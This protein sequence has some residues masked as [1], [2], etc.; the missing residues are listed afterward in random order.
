MRV[1][2]MYTRLIITEK[3]SVA[4]D[5]AKAL[6]ISN[7]KDGYMENGNTVITWAIG[8]LVELF[9]P[10]DYDKSLKNWSM[11][12]L[13]IIPEK[14][15]YKPIKRTLKQYRVV[16]KLIAGGIGEIVI[17]T[18]AGREGEV[19][20][21]TIIP[22]D[23]K[24]NMFRF[25]SSQSM[26]PN[27]VNQG[28]QN[29]KPSS[30]YD[31]LWEAG[32]SRQ[33]ADWMVGINGTRAATV[34]MN[35]MFSIGR[36]QTAVLA[37]LVDRRRDREIFIPEPYWNLRAHFSNEKGKWTGTWFNE[38]QTQFSTE[39][40]A[41]MVIECIEGSSGKVI[42]SEKQKGSKPPPF[43]YSLT[44]LQRDVN[45]KHGFSAKRT[46]E[47]AQACYEKHKCLSYPR[48]DSK[49]LGTENVKMVS[50]IIDELSKSH[51]GIFAGVKKDR[52]NASYGRI[53]DDSKLTDHHALI[54]LS[55][56]PEDIGADEGVIYNMVLMRFAAAF[57]P[58][59][60]YEK[61]KI[62][63]EISDQT[64]VTNENIVLSAGWQSVYEIKDKD[65][66]LPS[67]AKDDPAQVD[68]TDMGRKMTTPAPEYTEALLLKD[69][70]N[71]KRYL[72]KNFEST[73]GDVGLGTQATRAQIIEV[74]IKRQ[75]VAREKKH[76]VATDKGCQLIETIRGLDVTGQ[77]AS[78]EQTAKWEMRLNDIALG[79]GSGEDFIGDVKSFVRSM[80]DE[81]GS[82]KSFRLAD[83]PACGG[84]IIEGKKG[85]GCSNWRKEDGGCKFVIWKTVSGM[86]IDISNV[87]EMISK[88]ASGPFKL[89]RDNGSF[90]VEVE[91]EKI[92]DCPAC[93]GGIIE[94]KKGFGC[95]N[96]KLKVVNLSYGKAY[97]GKR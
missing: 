55:V 68:K 2:N 9:H 93:G 85:F 36:V 49:H 58:D 5:F 40:D 41:C 66:K 23:F 67:L 32:Q 91:R 53:F 65:F 4:R 29:L 60:E 88:N 97:P 42:S 25:W 95:S 44:D 28:M 52:I 46:L 78:P 83:C 96:W 90:R 61:T 6:G 75:Y 81:M 14:F 11:E 70:T 19:I 15:R 74:I 77:L 21:R 69:M 43:L 73:K 50:G 79:N 38:K 51:P 84:G 30:D 80:I 92:A 62:I 39:E 48:T 26:T 7:K 16:K 18:D 12:S 20:A 8:H 1:N 76:L 37:L 17:A 72:N 59:C 24:G 63:T 64:F 27:V 56:P 33:I 35:Q 3:P 34:K 86:K 22:S 54:P 13:P 71:P 47:L 10:E 82:I 45:Q 31:R 89:V 57:Y 94:G 87:R